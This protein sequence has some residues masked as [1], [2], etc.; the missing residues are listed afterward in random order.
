MAIH[1]GIQSAIF[2]YLSCAP[3]S[4]ARDRKRR[5]REAA[6]SRLERELLEA[7][8]PNLYRHPS[9]SSTNPHW[10]TE[11]AL[12]PTRVTR[13]KRK[14]NTGES[15]RGRK[16]G[17]IT[18]NAS[19]EP[20]WQELH[21]VEAT[22]D[23]NDSRWNFRLYQRE[24]EVLWGSSSNLDGSSCAESL[25]RPARVHTRDSV[26][27]SHQTFRNPPINDLHPAT[28]TKINSKE[29]VMWM[30]QPPP[31][32]EIMMG[33]ERPPRSRSDSGTSRMSPPSAAL[34]R[35]VSHRAARNGSRNGDASTP[36]SRESSSRA[37]NGLYGQKHDGGAA[38]SERD[39]AVS[40]VLPDVKDRLRPPPIHTAQQNSEDSDVT[41]VRRS[42][43]A[44][45]PSRVASRPQLTTIISDNGLAGEEASDFVTPAETPEEINAPTPLQNS[46]DSIERGDHIH[47]RSASLSH[48]HDLTAAQETDPRSANGVL[49]P[50]VTVPALASTTLQTPA[51]G[52]KHQDSEE[53]MLSIVDSWYTPDFELPKWVHEHTKREV[54]RHRWSMDL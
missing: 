14:T 34:S 42:S 18:S 5:K 25:R 44:P 52:H 22:N 26:T 2:Y 20:S 17:R 15:Q 39:F 31:V 12:G 40:P 47:E 43:L 53:A 16:A 49:L 46:I 45:Q 38:T 13:A 32:A 11:I 6:R 1:R 30:M 19:G 37:S 33:K 51:A 54:V 3:C 10:Q 48:E 28:V 35:Q 24:D 29:E 27:S 23:G 8:H 36:M 21:T 7:E 4:G 9:P 41:V 50:G